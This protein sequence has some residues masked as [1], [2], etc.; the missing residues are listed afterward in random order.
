MKKLLMMAALLGFAVACGGA[1]KAEE[2]TEEAQTPEV[3]VVVEEATESV[4]KAPAKSEP[5]VVGDERFEETVATQAGTKK[6]PTAVDKAEK[7]LIELNVAKGN[8]IKADVTTKVQ[9]ATREAKED[10]KTLVVRGAAT[11]KKVE[12]AA[13]ETKQAIEAVDAT[14]KVVKKN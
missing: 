13:E 2:N 8:E 4:A 9:A 7:E 14:V 12:K 1:N 3:E 6:A 10:T 11:A 5:E